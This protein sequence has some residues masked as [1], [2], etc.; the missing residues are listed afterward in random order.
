M[1][2]F[3]NVFSIMLRNI[4]T[5]ETT[6]YLV[7]EY[8][9]SKYSM[10]QVIC[11]EDGIALY[12]P[13]YAQETY[14]IVL[15][16]P[17]GQYSDMTSIME[18][19]MMCD[20]LRSNPNWNVAHI[21]AHF[22]LL[23]IVNDQEIA[24]Y[25]NV[26]DSVTGISPLQVAIQTKDFD[27][28]KAMVLANCKLDHVD[29]YLNTVYHYAATSTKNILCYLHEIN[30]ALLNNQNKSGL[31]ALHIACCNDMLENVTTLISLGADANIATTSAIDSACSNLDEIVYEE[32]CNLIRNGGTPLHYSFN[33]EIL[34]L[35]IKKSCS[36]NAVNLNQETALHNMVH[37]NLFENVLI[38]LTYNANVNTLNA[39]GYSVLRSA[40]LKL[41]FKYYFNHL[42]PW[43]IVTL[44]LI[45]SSAQNNVNIVQA[46]IA[47]NADVD[48][49]DPDLVS[50][51][52]G[53]NIATNEGKKILNI[54]NAV[55]SERCIATVS[56]CHK[57][58]KYNGDYNGTESIK[59]LNL[60]PRS[61]L[62]QM[63][64]VSSMGKF[65]SK[66]R[67]H[68]NGGRLLCLDG[69]GIKGLILIQMLYE[70]E[71]ILQKPIISCFDWIA[72]TSTGH[73]RE[74]SPN[75]IY[76]PAVVEKDATIFE[77]INMKGSECQGLYFQIKNKVFQGNR[78]YSSIPLEDTLINCFGNETPMTCIEHPKVMITATLG[79]RR[80]VDLHFFR[81]YTSSNDILQLPTNSKFKNTLPPC[82]QL[83]W[84]AARATGAA[85]TYFEAFGRF[86][87]GGVIAN[88]PTLDAITEI[89]EYNLALEAVGRHS[90]ITPLSLVVSLGTGLIPVENQRFDLHWRG[91]LKEVALL[92]RNMFNLVIDQATTTDG[93]MVDRARS[94]CSMI[95]VPYYRF[96]PQLAED[97]PLD[98]TNDLKLIDMMCTTRAY[99]HANRNQVKELALILK[100]ISEDN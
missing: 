11:R 36:I 99:M 19:Q 72:G 25:L 98:E 50:L 51:R 83:I 41:D 16:R 24:P 2:W 43:A 70:I 26:A 27:I 71:N 31:T 60:N 57:G 37:Q 94:W 74:S 33:T 91:N 5:S 20:I 34:K 35:I 10:R 47:F 28:V 88:N 78:P 29:L 4:F 69:G 45:L 86:I 68:K 17:V 65:S 85:P 7:I 97:V 96:N 54:L 92:L 79:D 39:E 23:D 38:L 73:T 46:L 82:E 44:P 53:T 87:D 9:A 13:L 61:I 40:I 6:E 80:P 63:L 93:R 30:P 52:H 49:A 56:H 15:H 62:D 8:N 55:G 32:K 75:A 66:P 90:E 100:S 22:S 77:R 18:I 89:Y 12:S 48:I 84:K 1:S 59:L 95:G 81:N 67:Q 42:F 64:Y 21:A 14:E 76:Q 3:G 58:C